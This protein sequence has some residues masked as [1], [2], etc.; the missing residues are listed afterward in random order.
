VDFEFARVA[1]G[2]RNPTGLYDQIAPAYAD[3]FCHLLDFVILRSAAGSHHRFAIHALP[4]IVQFFGD[5]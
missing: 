1:A 5:R 4:Q 3:D 2:C